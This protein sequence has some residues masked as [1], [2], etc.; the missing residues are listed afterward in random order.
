MIHCIGDS[1][2][3][4]FSGKDEMQPIWPDKSNDGL[5]NFRSYRIGAATA[6]NLE[7]KTYI[8]DQIISSQ[9]NE[10][11]TVV[12]CFG[13]VDIRAHIIKQAVFQNRPILD[14]VKECVSRYWNVICNYRSLGCKMAVWGPIA[15]W[16]EEKPYSGPSYGT[17]EERNI[18]TLLF[19]EELRLLSK[20]SDIKIISIFEEITQGG[21]TN[22]Y[23]LDDWRGCHIHLNS[24]ALPLIFEAFEKENLI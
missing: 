8:I 22:P 3:S 12:F 7:T 18:T 2:S 1:H 14:L 16:S 20:D 13:E 17:D 21:V 6:Y 19:T 9:V 23:Y 5:E 10:E 4:I 15:S 24:N 11:D